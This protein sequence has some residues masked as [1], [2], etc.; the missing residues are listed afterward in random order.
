MITTALVRG[1]A[2]STITAEM[3][4]AMKPGSVIVDLAASGGGNCELT[5]PGEKIVTDNGVTIIGYKRPDQPDAGA[6]LAA[7]RHEHRQPAQAADPRQGRPAGPRHGRHRPAG[8]H[9]HPRRRGAVAAAR[10]CRCRPHRPAAAVDRRP[11]TC[12]PRPNW[13][14]RRAAGSSGCTRGSASPRLRSGRRSPSRRR[15]S[16]GYFTVFV[17]AVFVGFYVIT[18]VSASLHTPLMAQTNAISGIIL[19][20]ALLQLGST[21]VAGRGAGVHRGDRRL[22]QH[23][24]RLRGRRPDDLDVPEGR[25]TCA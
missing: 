1:R 4:R 15:V 10:R 14:S 9:R 25:V 5:V 13:P 22:D 24:R 8:D 16:S 2:P 6:H 17:L 20:G 12:R 23:L 19:V 21:N 18:N 7:V 11:G 3:V